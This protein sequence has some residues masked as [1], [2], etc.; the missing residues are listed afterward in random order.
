MIRRPPRSTL[1][2]YTTLFRSGRDHTPPRRPDV[3]QA[4]V[5]RRLHPHHH[6]AG[7]D[8]GE[9]ARLAA[10]PVLAPPQRAQDVRW[11]AAEPAKSPDSIAGQ[12]GLPPRQNNAVAAEI[13]RASCRERV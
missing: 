7:L 13:G 8:A 5:P 4:R 11:L 6:E 2:P 10:R 9:L 1:F 12:R 3:L